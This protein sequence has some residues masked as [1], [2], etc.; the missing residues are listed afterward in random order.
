MELPRSEQVRREIS[1]MALLYGIVIAV[2]VVGAIIMRLGE[3]SS[4][5]APPMIDMPGPF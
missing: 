4:G 2:L 5:I 1:S 3:A